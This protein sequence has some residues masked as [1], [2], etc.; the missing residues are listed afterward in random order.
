MLYVW[1]VFWLKAL[2]VPFRLH[3]GCCWSSWSPHWSKHTFGFSYRLSCPCL[4]DCLGYGQWPWWT[5]VCGLRRSG[6]IHIEFGFVQIF[7]ELLVLLEEHLW[8]DK[9]HWLVKQVIGCVNLRLYID[10]ELGWYAV[11]GD[12]SVKGI[13]VLLSLVE[14]VCVV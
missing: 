2:S 7:L 13:Q 12:H 3:E 8:L 4:L 14:E 5:G 10:M 1:F 9:L 6:S 11:P